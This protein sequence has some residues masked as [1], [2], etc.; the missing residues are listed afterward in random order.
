M[1]DPELSV[2]IRSA[3]RETDLL[4]ELPLDQSLEDHNI[5][6]PNSLWHITRYVKYEGQP[7]E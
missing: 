4:L 3:I 2:T 5:P 6:G 7:E 1:D